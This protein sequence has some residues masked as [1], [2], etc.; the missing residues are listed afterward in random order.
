MSR[1]ALA[2]ALFTGFVVTACGHA[3]VPPPTNQLAPGTI[4]WPSTLDHP[5]TPATHRDAA[6][7]LLVESGTES[8]MV[9]M[10]EIMLKQQLELHP[11]IRPY[12][13][14]LRAF[15]DKYASF[16]ALRDDLAK[17]YVDRFTELQ[18]RQI[19]AFYQTPT[20]QIAVRELPKVIELAAALGKNRVSEHMDELKDMIL[21]KGVGAPTP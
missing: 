6:I 15:L 14:V 18:L 8:A 12:Q 1:C 20:G 7:R 10:Q 4:V 9:T 21:K 16:S 5:S 2:L 19:L 11:I 17:L 13:D 3:P